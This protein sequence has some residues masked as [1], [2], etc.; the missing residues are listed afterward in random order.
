MKSDILNQSAGDMESRVRYLEEAYHS[1]V[2]L[3]TLL[4]SLGNFQTS[5][6]DCR[7][8]AK[9]L[10][11][12][13]MH[14]QRLLSFRATAFAMVNPGDFNFTI[15]DCEPGSDQSLVQSLVDREI[16]S[17]T[18]AWALRQNHA[19]IIRKTFDGS[20][21]VLHVIATRSRVMG[22]FVGLLSTHDTKGI[23]IS[24]NLLSIIL[25]DT[26][27]A[28]ENLSL[29]NEINDYNQNLE[30]IV[31]KRT[32]ELLRA[33]EEL[34]KAKQLESV[35]ILAG[36]IAH[37]FN[38]MLA[39]ILGNISIAKAL[40]PF[41][42]KSSAR[43]T[44]AEEACHQAKSLTA[45][46]LTF[47]KGGSP[48]RK[49]I[50]L[51]P[52]IEESAQ[53]AL[54]G[55]QATCQFEIASDLF[56]V[57]ADEGQMRHVIINLVMNAQ[58]SMN[59]TGQVRI[60]GQNAV[61]THGH[62]LPLRDGRYA[63]IMVIDHGCGILQENLEKIF[64]PYFTTKFGKGGFGLTI[65]QSIV[66]KHEGHITVESQPGSGSTFTVYLPASK[67]PAV[68]HE[69]RPVTAPA[70]AAPPPA[71]PA[72]RIPEKQISGTQQRQIL[73]MDD[74][75]GIR[76]VLGAI[77]N[78]LGHEVSFARDGLEAVSLYEAA[79]KTSK[80]FHLVILDLTVPGGVGGGEAIGKLLTVDPKAKAI[81]SSGYSND[82]IM[83][84][85]RKFGFQAAL[86]KPYQMSE[87]NRVLRE[88][89]N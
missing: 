81:A 86:R 45:R 37:D 20:P 85:A 33:N 71:A 60:V 61:L 89:L 7:D 2:E 49:P 53:F 48:I 38:N 55:S 23:D 54:T 57:E 27:Y 42:S 25:L 70:V 3:L 67:H 46:L 9:I 1:H 16:K 52:L 76:D 12:T 22:M 58:Q 73:V 78:H 69:S 80:P 66:N 68:P 79:Q 64:N 39:V 4:A 6:Q 82:P 11:V 10:G 18:F 72:E 75:K 84:D 47:S 19:V 30:K 77:L 43:L 35:G 44:T 74:E 13:R 88:V 63:K 62:G 51:A 28:L 40:L 5:I 83:S 17:G 56:S 32:Q 14:L 59:N 15:T 34:L 65:A 8:P 50:S 29:Y 21:M 41:D 36:G 26:A 31:A 24:L 87:L